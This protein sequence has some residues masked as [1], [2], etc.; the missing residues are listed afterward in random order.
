MEADFTI[1]DH[2]SIVMVRPLTEAATEWV[3]ENVGIEPWAWMGDA[4]ACDHRMAGDLIAGIESEGFTI[5]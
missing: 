5:Q 4:F 3:E 2:G 1:T